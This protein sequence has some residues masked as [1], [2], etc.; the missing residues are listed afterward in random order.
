ML[1]C[2]T[3][4]NPSKTFFFS[5]LQ[6]SPICVHI[7]KKQNFLKV[8]YSFLNEPG[9]V[10]KVIATLAGKEQHEK[11]IETSELV[12]IRPGIVGQAKAEIR[13]ERELDTFDVPATRCVALTITH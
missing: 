4:P 9:N 1:K 10:I 5:H 8:R 12:I 7:I 6:I 2:S 11:N 13:C 3:K